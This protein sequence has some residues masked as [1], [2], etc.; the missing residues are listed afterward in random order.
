MRLNKTGTV[1]NFY[2]IT[3]IESAQ[4]GTNLVYGY[5]FRPQNFVPAK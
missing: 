1:A 3:A 5:K 2:I 4:R